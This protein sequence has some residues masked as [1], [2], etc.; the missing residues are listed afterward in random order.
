MDPETPEETA[1]PPPHRRGRVGL[2]TVLGVFVLFGLVVLTGLSL[3]GRTLIIPD[4]VRAQLESR[5]NAGLDEGSVRLG[6]IELAVTREGRAEL[7]VRN[8]TIGDPTGAKLADLNLLRSNVPL[9]ALIRGEVVPSVIGLRGAQVT[10]RRDVAGRFTLS[11]G[12]GVERRAR[13][14]SGIIDELEATLSLPSLAGIETI[15]ADGLTITLEDARTGRLWQASNAALRLVRLDD[16]LSINVVSEIFNG[17]D[18]LAEVR[19]SARSFFDSS[20]AN[21]GATIAAVPASDIAVQAPALSYLGVLDA[22]I[23]G[24]IRTRLDSGGA[25]EGFAATLDIAKGAL[26]PVPDAP[27]VPFERGRAHFTFDPEDQRIA[28]SEVSVRSDVLALTAEGQAW[29]GEFDG[30]W[31]ATLTGQLTLREARIDPEGVFERPVAIEDGSADF[32]IRLDPFSVDVGR[33]S[34]RVDGARLTAS[35]RAGVGGSDWDVALDA[36]ID[37]IDTD[38]VIAH[39]PTSLVPKTRA[40]LRRNVLGGTLTDI[41]AA[42]RIADGAPPISGLSF[43]FTDAEVRYLPRMA[44]LSGAAGRASL[45][46]HRFVIA[47]GDGA[48]AGEAGTVD[49]AGSVFAVPDIRDTPST[50][51]LDLQTSATLPA[52]LAV[53]S[54]P[55]IALL[56]DTRL[57]PGT[58]AGRV[59]LST[60]IAFETGR[61][62][63][64]ADMELEGRGILSDVATDTLAEGRRL[65][66]ARLD[67]AF[68]NSRVRIEGPVAL[69]GIAADVEWARAIGRD[70]PPGGGRVAGTTELSG[71]TLARLGL[72]LPPGSISGAAEA[73]FEIELPPEDRPVARLASDLT[74][75]GLAIPAVGWAKPDPVAGEFEAILRLGEPPAFEALS[76]RAPGLR[77][78]DIE[79]QLTED[80]RL[81]GLRV[82]ALRIGDWL[83]APVSVVPTAGGETAIQVQGGAID[84][85]SIDLAGGVGGQ[86]EGAPGPVRLEPDRVIVSDTISLSGFSGELRGGSGAFTA[87][88][89]GRTPIRGSV[90]PVSGGTAIRILS[91]D[92]GGVV[93]DAGFLRNASGGAF[94]LLLSPSGRP[95][96]YNGEL[97]IEDVTVRDAPALA[98]LLDAISLVG[99]LDDGGTGIRFDTVDARFRL[100]PNGLQLLRSAAVGASMGISM[101]GVYDFRSKR[102]DMQGVISPIYVLNGIGSIFTRRGEGIFGFSFRMTGDARAPRI[103]INPLSLLTPGMFREIF[104]RP[105][106]RVDE[107]APSQ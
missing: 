105:P 49:V 96:F 4:I 11:Y 63:T 61:D 10:I 37:R 58:F 100:S 71:D 75:L 25:V 54:A 51:V 8:V 93:R 83:D 6:Q 29:L 21:L 56:K 59:D 90:I 73:E 43:D 1:P 102:I 16:G 20:R 26:R 72:D 44:P 9:A 84:I 13:D 92:A 3:T 14:I 66:A 67:L 22:P 52:A 76:L 34:A 24:A 91:E 107:A 7:L 106:P 98:A 23:S 74:G 31:P 80:Q 41:Q 38:A 95:G 81:A 27:A 94:D 85:R 77:A 88:I 68:D 30:N 5:L 79:L 33:L 50:I 65:E 46:D 89:N 104:R 47:I 39:W 2:W 62:P 19:F 97:L 40:W 64:L 36:G 42:L 78:D 60:R 53:L 103:A 45:H 101:D 15:R 70:A 35:A 99:L 17:T 69:D 57:S 12:G 82:P 28:F 48:L 86:G 87:R 32:R 55:P 18:E